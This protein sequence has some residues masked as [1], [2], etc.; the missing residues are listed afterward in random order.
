MD[1][2]VTANN[3]D[4][5]E[6]LLATP[7]DPIKRRVVKKLLVSERRLESALQNRLPIEVASEA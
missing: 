1:K 3:I 2:W 5:F 4:N 7:L 6:R